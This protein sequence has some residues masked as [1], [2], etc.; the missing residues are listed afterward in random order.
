M[1]KTEL[2]VMLTY[3]DLT[4]NNAIEVFNDNKDTPVEYW[5]IKE[6]GIP[7]EEMKTLF[8]CMKK[9][10][11]KT[12]LEVVAYTEAECMKGAQTAAE[13]GCDLLIGTLFFDSVNE[14]CEKQG[15]AYMPYVGKV[16]ERPSILEGSAEGMIK[17]AD[18]YV[19]KGAFGINLLGY[20]HVSDQFDLSKKVVSGL[21]SRVSLAGG[22]NS[23]DRLA[24]V[25]E[26]SPWGFTI[27]SAFFDK[28][29]GDS[30]K[31]QI[32]N[33]YEYINEK[34]KAGAI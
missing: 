25:K 15:I 10:G 34:E 30:F 31:E 8:D 26:I 2:I 19:N 28:K 13:C 1:Q 23:F 20:R 5:G 3:N 6:E 16:S 32:E 21:S 29:F 18:E 17:E 22:I 4:V 27:G 14:F 33:V 7:F 24:E 12:V 11:K 9:Y